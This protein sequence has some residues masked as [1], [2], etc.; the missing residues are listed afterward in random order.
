MNVRTITIGLPLGSVRS[1]GEVQPRLQRLADTLR[2]EFVAREIA[3]R[4]CRVALSPIGEGGGPDGAQPVN[5]A[6][7][8]GSLNAVA[9]AC[10]ELGI[11][12]FCVPFDMTR[13]SHAAT[14]DTLADLAFEVIKRHPRSFVHLICARDGQIAYD[15]ITRASRL[16]KHVSAIEQSGYHNFRVGVGCNIAPGTPF[17]PFA[18]SSDELG[19]SIGLEM[20]AAFLSVVGGMAGASLAEI[21]EALLVQLLPGIREVHDIALRVAAEQGVVFHGIDVSIAPYPE[22][23]GSVAQIMELLGLE[24]Y[25]GHGT[26]FITAYLTD[27]L[28]EL[29]RRGGLRTVG[30]NGVMLS[31]LEDEYMGRRNSYNLYSIDSLVLYSTVCGCGVDMVPVPGDSF[32]EEIAAM[33]LDVA[34]ASTVLN[35]PL[36][37]RILPIPTKQANEFTAFNMEFL[38]NTRI[39]KMRDLGFVGTS[40]RGA[41]FG[42]LM[43]PGPRESGG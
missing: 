18:Y 2:D 19:F 8:M 23:N 40:I 29:I 3:V 22:T 28:K 17:F 37:V 20:P 31:L 6:V 5:A 21:R 14:L 13:G 42:F 39:K 41:P 15:A 1:L 11:R 43:R 35:K 7:A 12:W 25:G 4:T 30:F 10:E 26:L 33:I 27:I 24:Q 32:E 9:Q 38:F 36:G 34:T 16:I